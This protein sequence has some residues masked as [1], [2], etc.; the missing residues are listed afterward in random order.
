MK[1][2]GD[3]LNVVKVL[4]D[5]GVDEIAVMNIDEDISD[6]IF[7]M[8]KYANR[9]ISMT[10]GVSSFE[11]AE[12]LIESGF[13]RLGVTD[14]HVRGLQVFERIEQHFGASSLVVNVRTSPSELMDAACYVVERFA[15]SEYVFH[16]VERAG[17]LEGIRR[18]YESLSLKFKG[19]NIGV[20]GGYNGGDAPQGARVY[21]SAKSVF[22]LRNSRIDFAKDGVPTDFILVPVGAIL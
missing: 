12:R 8:P 7:E 16:D 6:V 10:G 20:S 14:P 2:L 21:Y 4:S 22:P 17:T 18:E 19:V 13:D 15:A 9:P 5:F 1:Y 3:P 11:I